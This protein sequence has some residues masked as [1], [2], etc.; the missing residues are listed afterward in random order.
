MIELKFKQGIVAL[1]STVQICLISKNN[2]VL[3]SRKLIIIVEN[4]N[5]F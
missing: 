3:I 4:N 2:S 5:L 1:N